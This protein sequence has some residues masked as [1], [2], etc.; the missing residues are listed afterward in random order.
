MSA[1]RLRKHCIVNL[2]LNEWWRLKLCYF[3]WINFERISSVLIRNHLFICNSSR[4]LRAKI[5]FV[6]FFLE[7]FF[8]LICSLWIWHQISKYFSSLTYNFICGVFWHKVFLLIRST[9]L[10]ICLISLPLC[11]SGDKCPPVFIYWFHGKKFLGVFVCFFFL[12]L[13]W[14]VNPKLYLKLIILWEGR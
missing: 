8:N 11:L 1:V 4:T 9:S 2:E 13:F 5:T 7:K 12:G 14:S 10:W 6:I 3:Y